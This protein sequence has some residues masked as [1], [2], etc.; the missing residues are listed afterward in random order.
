MLASRAGSIEDVARRVGVSIR[1]DG[2]MGRK[3]SPHVRH[4]Y[5]IYGQNRQK[6]LRYEFGVLCAFSGAWMGLLKVFQ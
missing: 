4:N 6:D 1:S 2:Q 3:E 5:S